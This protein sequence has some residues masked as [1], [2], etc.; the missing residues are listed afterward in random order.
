[1]HS[2]PLCWHRLQR[3]VVKSHRRLD[4]AQAWQDLR[5]R[6]CC[7]GVGRPDTEVTVLDRVMRESEV[8]CGREIRG[9]HQLEL[10]GRSLLEKNPLLTAS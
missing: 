1:M 7:I 3:G 6:D 10:V 2:L 4:L 5:L 9:K 8:L